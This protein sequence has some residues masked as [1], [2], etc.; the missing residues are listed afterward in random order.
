MKP[1]KPMSR[2]TDTLIYFDSIFVII[3]KI[4]LE[5]GNYE[6]A[7]LFDM[8]LKEEPERLNTSEYTS[9]YSIVIAVLMLDKSYHMKCVIIIDLI[10]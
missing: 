4:I 8:H 10:M 9:I 6:L 2:Q 1:H 7:N 3:G 5:Y